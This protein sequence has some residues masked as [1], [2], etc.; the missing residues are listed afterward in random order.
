MALTV[1][2]KQ[3]LA[4]AALSIANAIR[5]ELGL[6]PEKNLYKGRRHSMCECPI[7]KTID[8]TGIVVTKEEIRLDY[9]KY[10]VV[11]PIEAPA[12]N[13]IDRRWKTPAMAKEF[14]TY[15]DAGLIPECDE[16]A[17]TGQLTFEK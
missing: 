17:P 6:P 16:V 11:I 4:D 7:A 15:F 12:K 10:K 1:E 5:V 2:Q 13:W 3:E 8:V 9:D 14:I